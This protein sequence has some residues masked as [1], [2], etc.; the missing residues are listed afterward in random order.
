MKTLIVTGMLGAGKTTFVQNYLK[1]TTE[2]T[3]VLVND[4]GKLGI[5]AELLKSDAGETIELPSG[6][7]CCTLKF[8]LITTLNR[9]IS[10]IKP[11]QLI[12]EPSGIASPSGIIEALNEVGI[13]EYTVIGIIDSVDFLDIYNAQMYGEFFE[14]Q[15]RNS[16]ILLINKIDLVTTQ[17]V[18]KIVKILEALNQSAIILPTVKAK[19]NID[20]PHPRVTKKQYNNKH[21]LHVESIAVSLPADTELAT[22]ESLFRE[23]LEKKHGNVFRAKALFTS[24]EGTFVVDIA[25]GK[26]YTRKLDRTVDR[27]RLVIVTD[28]ESKERIKERL[29]LL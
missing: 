14:D 22:I 4:F 24:P 16:D 17:D 8:D 28:H 9:I 23:L 25:S 18:L 1:H 11:Q 13:T 21:H 7:V 12:V 2:K 29:S 3:V 26:L 20:L 15:I 19:I 6:C 10:D 27:G 5:D